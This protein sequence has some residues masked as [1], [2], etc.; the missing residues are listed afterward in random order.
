MAIDSLAALARGSDDD[1]LRELAGSIY[2]QLLY[3]RGDYDELL[4]LLGDPEESGS[5]L[6]V[7]LASLPRQTIKTSEPVGDRLEVGPRGHP[8]V[9]V[10]ANGHFAV[11]AS[12]SE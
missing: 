4:P 3:D 5:R 8:S 1:G 9:L 10:E 2:A 7:S 12:G 11:Y 6:V